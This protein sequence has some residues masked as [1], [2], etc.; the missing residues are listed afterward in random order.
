MSKKII[1]TGGTSGIGEAAVKDLLNEG[2][3]VIMLARN[4]QKASEMMS[5]KWKG[6]LDYIPCDLTDLQSV[7][8]ATIN[9]K[10]DFEHVDVL[11]NNAGAI[12]QEK[13][14]TVDGYERTFAINHLGHFMLTTELIDLL[15]ASNTRV[16]NVSSEAHKLGK[17]DFEDLQ[18]QTRNYSS[19]NAYGLG[20]LCNIFFTM[21]LHKRYHDRGLSSYACHPGV[22]KSNFA[23]DSAGMVKFL[24]K[25]MQ[26][27]MISPEKGALTQL[28]LTKKEGIERLSGKY[29]VKQ[30]LANTASQAK[31]QEAALQL[32]EVSEE[33][34][35]AFR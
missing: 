23:R 9:I 16:I 30:K 19:M 7:K 34:V 32:W 25:A 28:F 21:E 20:K 15:I 11:M 33:L 35:A 18:W 2:W 12:I 14:I 10:A 5:Q 29:F 8:T 6:T 4:H 1:I 3:H 31:E 22:V 27:F 17:M 26:P 24:F 13:E